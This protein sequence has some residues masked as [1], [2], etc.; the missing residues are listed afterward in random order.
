MYS[1]IIIFTDLD[2]DH[3]GKVG[4]VVIADGNRF[5]LVYNMFKFVRFVERLHKNSKI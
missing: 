5:G 1:R 2:R 3:H 4:C